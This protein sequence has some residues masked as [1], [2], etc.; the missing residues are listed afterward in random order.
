VS[1]SWDVV[2]IGAGHNGLTCAAYLAKAGRKVVVLERREVIGGMAA[3][4]EF[5][6][7]YRSAGLLQDT[8]GIWRR[9][10]E[11]LALERHGLALRASRPET[12][13][14]GEGERGLLLDGDTAATAREIGVHSAKDAEA[15]GR[16][17][18]FL[19][20]IRSLLAGYLDEPP[21][22]L[23]EIES[24][25]LWDLMRQALRVR[26]LGAREMME[27]LRLPSLSVSDWLGEF[28]E[29][30]LLKAALALPAVAGTWMGPRS[31]WSNSNLLLWEGAAGPGAVGGGPA[32]IGAL[33]K[34][35]RAHGAEIRTGA[36]VE[37]LLPGKDG[38]LGVRIAGGEELSA[39]VVA[40]SCEPKR[41]LLGLL[42]SGSIQSRLEHRM[43]KYRTRGTT[44]QVLLALGSPLR[45]AC[46]KDRDIE[47]ARTG[48]DLTQIEKAFD[49]VKYGKCSPTPV[50]EIHVPTVSSPDLAPKG[51]GVASLLVH[52][53]PYDLD[54][55]W[56]EGERE[57]LGDRA[58]E[59]LE[60]HAPGLSSAI[61][62]R[63]I[64]GPVDLEERYALTEGHVHH[65]EHSVDQLLIRPA[66]ECS[67]YRTPVPGL[68][69]CGGGTHPGGGLTCRPGSLAASAILN[70]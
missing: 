70:S 59:V 27:V 39:R 12:L 6:P 11:D 65:G 18:T 47:L 62:G 25:G 24:V 19:S 15:Y 43:R 63:R 4:E 1:A 67:G 68:F 23:V 33:E 41:V 35:A 46:R 38:A 53:A 60:G 30:D 28:F 8:T 56:D 52:F 34:A 49:A 48:N 69:L 22:N 44:A 64:L 13:A 32:L 3:S 31:P 61:K 26:R 51:H 57:R 45:F 20:R 42:P 55:G 9:V 29:T 21:R 36:Q 54:P 7:G 10:V 58:V 37:R 16:Y 40:A 50:L 17:R 5:H 66:P 2:V 14:L